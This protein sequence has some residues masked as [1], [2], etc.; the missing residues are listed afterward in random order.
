MNWMLSLAKVYDK[1]LDNSKIQNSENLLPLY[2]KKQGVH[3]LVSIS[4]KG[5]FLGARYNL[6]KRTVFNKK[7]EES[8]EYVISHDVIPASAMSEGATSENA[9]HPLTAKIKHL[10][11]DL[12][13]YGMKNFY[14]NY[15]AELSKWT[16]SPFSHVKAEAVLHY[17]ENNDVIQDLVKAQIISLDQD[18][19]PYIPADHKDV[20]TGASI[21]KKFIPPKGAQ[22]FLVGWEVLHKNPSILPKASEDKTLIKSWQD[23]CRWFEPQEYGVGFCQLTGENVVLARKYPS[24]I[25]PGKPSSRLYSAKESPGFRFSGRMPDT[26]STLSDGCFGFS[27]GRELSMKAHFALSWMISTQKA[28]TPWDPNEATVFWSYDEKSDGDEQLILLNNGDDTP[29]SSEQIDFSFDDFEVS[30]I[31]DCDE[32]NSGL[33]LA[34]KIQKALNGRRAKISSGASIN[35]ISVQG[36]GDKAAHM[37]MTRFEKFS[38][39]DYFRKL[40]DWYSNFSCLI[41]STD[42]GSKLYNP[43]VEHIVY[44]Y[45]HMPKSSD[46]KYIKENIRHCILSGDNIDKTIFENVFYRLTNINSFKSEKKWR[47]A[48]NVG[49]ALMRLY[50]RRSSHKQKEYPVSLDKNY[51]SRDYLFGR[52]LAVADSIEAFSNRKA[53][54]ERQTNTKQMLSNLVSRPSVAYAELCLKLMPYREKL[55]KTHPAF[56]HSREAIEREIFNLMS[57]EDFNDNSALGH[58]WILGYQ[59]QE[60]DLYR[61]NATQDVSNEIE[62]DE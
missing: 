54:I 59:H 23:Y 9:C 15:H 1:V 58:E 60:H 25:L 53:K 10:A 24:G 7:G 49:V 18:N 46:W 51:N 38:S 4:E 16:Q 5:E 26:A 36:F 11:K 34:N 33:L 29:F 27:V 14:E 13:K 22:E 21:V 3:L 50:Y 12:D 20:F 62:H 61:K 8:Y 40:E 2:H 41:N 17:L 55:E 47:Y 6:V 31:N 44:A 19:K 35:V 30:T 45:S 56:I 43:S 48:I 32:F 37:S 52:L 57:V 28:C 42:G 39:S